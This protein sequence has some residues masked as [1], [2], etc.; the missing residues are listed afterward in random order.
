MKLHCM[1]LHTIK[2]ILFNV[3]VRVSHLLDPLANSGKTG[4][5]AGSVQEVHDK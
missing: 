5:G 3:F 2:Y 4:R 1:H